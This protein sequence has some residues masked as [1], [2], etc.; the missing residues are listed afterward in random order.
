MQD[1]N[2]YE[3]AGQISKLY[4]EYTKLWDKIKGLQTSS[5]EYDDDLKLRIWNEMVNMISNNAGEFCEVTSQT[6]LVQVLQTIDT[7]SGNIKNAFLEDTIKS[8]KANIETTTKKIE[9]VNTLSGS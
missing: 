3:K 2:K 5:S 6:E 8:L 7:A 4:E 1:I 9:S